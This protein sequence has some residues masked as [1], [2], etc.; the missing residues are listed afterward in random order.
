MCIRNR[1][2]CYNLASNCATTMNFGWLIIFLKRGKNS[3]DSDVSRDHC[4][5]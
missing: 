4:V 2:F 3:H 1:K 5:I